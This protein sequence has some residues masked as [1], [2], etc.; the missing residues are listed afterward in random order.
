MV[1]ALA[2]HQC[3]PGSTP[4]PGVICGLSLL[5]V[6]VLAPRG[7]S[8]GTPVFSGFPLSKNQ[9]FQIPIRSGA[10]EH[11]Q[12]RSSEL[13]SASRVNKL[14]LQ[15]LSFFPRC[16]DV[17]IIIII[18]III[19]A[20]N[21][22]C[23]WDIYLQSSYNHRSVLLPVL[24]QLSAFDWLMITRAFFHWE[25][26]PLIKVREVEQRDNTYARQY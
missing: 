23:S 10:H 6:L 7:F 14:R 19:I 21:A 5:L 11:F 8:P 13:L 24:L 3:G 26:L 20:Q 25:Y 22:H 15:K 9:Y 17:I 4:G 1:R 18:I 12:T 16:N 2:S